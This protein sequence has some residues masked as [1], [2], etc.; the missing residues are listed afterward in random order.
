MKTSEK[1][2]AIIQIITTIILL[3]DIFVTNKL[4]HNITMIIFL[5]SITGITIL[6]LGYEKKRMLYEKD[7]F[8]NI[9]IYCFLYYIIIYLSGL[10]IGF[11]RTRYSLTL[12]GIL[13][14]T[15]PIIITIIIS[16]FLRYIMVSKSKNNKV[17]LILTCIL[18]V[19]IDTRLISYAYDLNTNIGL[20]K[21]VYMSVLPILS[22]NIFLTYLSYKFG[23]TPNI[24]YR[25]IMEIPS[26][27]I[28][29]VPN[30]NDYFKTVIDLLLP[31]FILWRTYKEFGNKKS[32]INIR[33]NQVAGRMTTII[34]L[35]FLLITIA[36][37]SGVF[38]YYALAIGSNSMKP[39][40]K[41]GDVVIVEKIA[42]ENINT[43]KVGEVLVYK[44]NDIVIVHRI[45]KIQEVDG[46]YY[47]RTKGD[48]NATE[49][50][51]TI[52]QESVVGKAVIQI[53]YIGIPTVWL[54]EEV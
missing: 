18:F 19:T 47:F 49:D 39:R 46:K 11:L 6:L 12:L 16:E 14:N 9:L 44:Y 29:I 30:V 24:N 42:Q 2:L 48:N 37:T 53:P 45:I 35:I 17:L 4:S 26:Y 23:F 25:I 34:L 31:A 21:L 50:G 20:V 43:L 7:I 51:W 5:A 41:K 54:S 3:L 10:I 1:K 8:L 40:I 52:N 22:K 38:K 27:I 13:R 28:P 32:I 36:L 15:L 33:K